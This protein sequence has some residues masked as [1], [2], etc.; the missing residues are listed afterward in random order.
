MSDL[1]SRISEHHLSFFAGVPTLFHCHH[2]NLFL[3]Q[4]IDDALGA[5]AGP[6]LRRKAAHEAAYELLSAACGAVGASTPIERIT[7]AQGVFKA[8]GHGTLDLQLEGGGGGATGQNLH[9]GFSWKEK[10]G[11]DIKRRRPADGFAEGF[12]A[13]ASEVALEKPLWT[14][15]A[16]EVACVSMR[17]EVCR[18]EIGPWVGETPAPLARVDKAATQRLLG[19][20]PSG[21]FESDIEGIA[22]GLVE[23]LGG[24]ASDDRGL[25]EAFGVFVTL[26]LA[27]YYNRISYEAVDI[28]RKSNPPLVPILEALLRESG[29][30]CV[31]H[32]FG[33]ILLSP[34][35]EGLVGKPDGSI[36]EHVVGCTAIARA[37]G[38]GCWT[39][40]E[41]EPENRLVLR[42][43]M[44]YETPYRVLRSEKQPAPSSYFL[45]GAGLA[46]MEL[47]HRLDWSGSPQL[48]DSV[49]R[50]IFS[51]GAQWKVE[52][53]ADVAMGDEHCEVVVSRK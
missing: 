24:V 36:Q 14:L 46:F 5:E 27:G 47:A 39:V 23:F 33:G 30:V 29:Q 31:F 9:Y 41:L 12:V 34:E 43:P 48:D 32:T 38:F 22:A 49:Y 21:A 19:P 17:A 20:A 25:V 50:S 15:D 53:T 3:D 4:T 42:A 40:Q 7:I 11:R 28:V 18:F 13:A 8:M 16:R 1:P 10:Y 52:Q 44:T 45:Q 26:H 35:W 37:L 2:F 6:A 51:A